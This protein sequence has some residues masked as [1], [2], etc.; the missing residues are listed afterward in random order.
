MLIFSRYTWWVG[1]MLGSAVFL[2]A[3]GQVGVLHPV[4]GVF[5]VLTR[6]AEELLTSV[7]RP[8]AGFLSDA[9]SISDL[10]EENRRLRLENEELRTQSISLQADAERVKQLEAALKISQGST[11][12]QYL[13]A[14]I[15]H[16]DSSAFTDVVSIDRG[17]NSGVR[18]GMVVLSSQGSLMGTVT[19]VFSSRAFVR[20][21]TDSKSKVA[22]Q[23]ES[24]QAD[25]IVKGAANRTL[26]FD[27]AQADIKVG[28]IIITSAL[29]GRYPAGLPIGKVTDVSGTQQDL[30]RKVMLEP[31]VRL[32]TAS[33]VLVQTSFTPQNLIG[34]PD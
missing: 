23:V 6:P 11:N 5:L 3:A 15:V 27:L 16:R 17:T 20:L 4:Q 1:A 31:F 32:S 12:E 21:I 13:A 19:E 8:V 29:T 18:V 30:Y 26:T 22:A 2:A 7:F 28:D 34:A 24:S 14:N 9:G 25:G 33:T 10:R